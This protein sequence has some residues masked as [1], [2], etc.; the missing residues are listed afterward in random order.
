[1]LKSIIIV[2]RNNLICGM[3]IR[4]KGLI[5]G[6]FIEILYDMLLRSRRITRVVCNNNK[7]IIIETT[8]E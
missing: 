8:G 4:K 3:I 5:N 6:F 1:M 2:E 7:E